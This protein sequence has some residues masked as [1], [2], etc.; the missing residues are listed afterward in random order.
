MIRLTYPSFRLLLYLEWLLLA[1]AALMEVLH[2]FQS[3]WSLL[4]RVGAI[5]LFGA[6]GLRLPTVR[7]GR[8]V[9]FTALEFGLILLP[10]VQEGLSSRSSFL[11]FLVL[12]MR[13]CLIFRQPGQVTV[14]GVALLSYSSLLLL[15]PIL[16][17][18]VIATVWEWR[19]SNVL[20]FGLTLVFALLLINAL[21]AERQSREQLEIAHDKLA[22]THEQLRHYAL[23]IEDQA[24]L[25]ERNRIAREIHDGLGH[26]LAAQT[27][28]LNNA[29]LFWKSEDEKA[30]EFLKQ[31]KQLGSEALLEIRKSVSVLRSNPLQGLSLESAI[32]KLL[33]NFQRMTAIEVSN[34]IRL[35][36]LLSQEMNTTLYRIVQE[37][38]TNIHK[39]A[40]A[41]M[42]TVGL[43]QH[44][45]QVYLSIADNGKGFDPAQNTTG[46]GLQG[47]RERVAAAGGQFAIYSKS[48]N[49]CRI[50]VSL[51]SQNI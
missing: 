45:G 26:T 12:L 17:E 1:T 4:L 6:I 51:P 30:L 25:Q 18:K 33:Q 9:L 28:Q 31:A 20:L 37:S 5:A 7:L 40:D 46:F 43:Q 29:L 21:I 44:A 23:R 38:L 2:P 41:T 42:V 47:M 36:V 8:K 22:L 24:T 49:G 11:L 3:L 34:S 19:F 50:S 10:I 13:S 14:L 39:H 16:P 48:G 15:K 35:P 32:D 27:I